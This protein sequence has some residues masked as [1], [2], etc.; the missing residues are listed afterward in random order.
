[1]AMEDSPKKWSV[2]MIIA[3]RETSGQQGLEFRGEARPRALALAES[4]A[5]GTGRA[6]LRETLA[7]GLIRTHLLPGQQFGVDS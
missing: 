2:P 5:C 7:V 4:L 1:M 6:P 3:L